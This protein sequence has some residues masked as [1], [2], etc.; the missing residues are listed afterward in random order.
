MARWGGDGFDAARLGE[1]LAPP[2][3]SVVIVDPH[4]PVR[5]GLSL[6]LPRE[7]IAVLG[8]AST[9]AGGEALVARHEP[10]IA[11]VA[12]E[13]P[14]GDGLGLLRRL[15]ARG[16]R[17]AVVLYTDEDGDGDRSALAVHSGAAGMIA[18]RRTVEELAAALRAIAAGGLWFQDRAEGDAHRPAPAPPLPLPHAQRRTSALSS[19]E[20]RVLALVADGGSTEATA[21]ALSI[22]PHTVR[23]HMR[24]V[25]RKL[26]A[27]SRAHAV[28]IAI[29]EAAIE[30]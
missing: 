4:P 1:R 30:I 13:L 9:G 12:A 14:D 3:T 18:K 7:G 8:G 2:V 21:E 10:D 15:V 11:L 25:L 27:S 5:D 23:T 24:N 17:S 6:L 28:A 29:R 26:E 20:L 16:L 22:S 19:S